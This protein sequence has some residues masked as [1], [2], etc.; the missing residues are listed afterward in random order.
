MV[1]QAYQLSAN[2]RPS[3]STGDLLRGH[4][5]L[6]CG[7]GPPNE[8]VGGSTYCTIYIETMGLGQP[9][10]ERAR[11]LASTRYFPPAWRAGG[12]PRSLEGMVWHLGAE[13]DFVVVAS[14]HDLGCA[15]ALPVHTDSPMPF[16]QAVVVYTSGKFSA[17][18]TLW[19]ELGRADTLYTS[20]LFDSVYSLTVIGL[21]LIKGR[22]PRLVVGVRGELFEPAL[23][24]KRRRKAVVL[25][26]LKGLL[27]GASFHASSER[28]AVAIRR[29]FP[30]SP[31][32]VASDLRRPPETAEP[33]PR[34]STDSLRCLVL[35]RLA[36]I[37]NVEAA[38][39]AI[40]LASGDHYLTIAGPAE[41][42]DYTKRLRALSDQ[43]SAG[44]RV[45]FKGAVDPVDVPKLMS[46]HDLLLLPSWSEN[47]G[48]VVLEALLSGLP[49]I[50]SDATPWAEV[51]G[52]RAVS[53][54]RPGEPAE[55]A[56]MIDD[57]AR[58]SRTEREDSRREAVALGARCLVDPVAI[59]ATRK[60]LTP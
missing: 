22:R 1:G 34:V 39:R 3:T 5:P 49:V 19:R 54:F 37:K 13:I 52:T 31:I 20:S 51:S 4:P 14:D 56:R 15:N 42:A 12:P 44:R 33:T 58:S 21:W 53:T 28:E 18:R 57:Y 50:A 55:L 47:F 36:P 2:R 60:M 40:A 32:T 43:P 45:T 30:K 59:A 35:G 29:V 16:L 25:F 26:V 24:T 10:D 46:A 17:V 48:H 27:G 7:D 38:I 11:V 9:P 8:Q 6:A 41:D 23:R